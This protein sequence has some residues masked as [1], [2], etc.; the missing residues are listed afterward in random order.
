MS[1]HEKDKI[2]RLNGFWGAQR[3]DGWGSPM[4]WL[5]LYKERK[6]REEWGFSLEKL[7][8]HCFVRGSTSFYNKKFTNFSCWRRC[9]VECSN[10][11]K[12]TMLKGN[13]FVFECVSLTV[14]AF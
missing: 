14:R 10:V 7:V 8:S 5:F 1:T 3:L 4:V 2:V 13:Y 9:C 12:S 6:V 11:I